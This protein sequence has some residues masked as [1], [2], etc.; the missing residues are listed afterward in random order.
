[1]T[2]ECVNLIM[3]ERVVLFIPRIA[4]IAVVTWAVFDSR[5]NSKNGDKW[6]RERI[7]THTHVAHSSIKSHSCSRQGTDVHARFSDQNNSKKDT[8]VHD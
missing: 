3:A 5:G 7:H 6:G 8:K 2:S 1:M 4:F